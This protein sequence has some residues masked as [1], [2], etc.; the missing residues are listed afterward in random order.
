MQLHDIQT[1]RHAQLGVQVGQGLVKQ[2]HLRLDDDGTGQRHALLLPAGQLVGAALAVLRQAHELKRRFH[3]GADLRLWQL[4]LDQ[5]EGHVVPHRHVRP[6]RVVLEHHA[7]VA[8]PG[9]RAA[10]A[11][12]TCPTPTAPTGRRTRQARC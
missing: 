8:V 6:Q 7:D 1:Q 3:L 11:A 12:W 5:A 2:Q 9:R 4:A 10:A